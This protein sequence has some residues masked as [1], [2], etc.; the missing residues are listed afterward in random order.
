MKAIQIGVIGSAGNEE[1]MSKDDRNQLSREQIFKLAEEV[2]K[3][4]AL[5][6]V[7]VITGGKSGLME[8][9]S[10]GAKLNN[11]VTIGFV[12]GKSRFTSNEY[13]DFE[14]VSGMDGCGEETM[15]VLS[16]DGL[17]AI[18]GGS[19]T[20][21]EITIAYRNSKPIVCLDKPKYGWASALCNTYLD[22][23]KK[24]KLISVSSPKEAV[25]KILSLVSKQNDMIKKV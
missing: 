7:F 15:L 6:N 3:L 18:G 24:V 16:C 1:Y 2:G 21:Q 11:G 13:V 25:N 12:S 17:I 22:D 8:S 19:G 10:K 9:A 5:K 20:L 4:L 23:R 14:V